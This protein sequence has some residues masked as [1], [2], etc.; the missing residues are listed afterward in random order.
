[1]DPG[2]S[3]R[4]QLW[5]TPATGAGIVAGAAGTAAGAPVRPRP[6]S[7][8]AGSAI[9][10]GGIVSSVAGTGAGLAAS[11]MLLAAGISA[12]A[13]VPPCAVPGSAMPISG[14]VA[15]TG[16][17]GWLYGSL[18]AWSASGVDMGWLNGASGPVGR[19]VGWAV[20]GAGAPTLGPVSA[21][22]HSSQK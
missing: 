3:G 13:P 20:A 19:L 12:S 10:A 4:P 6:M 18:P 9:D 21:A 16:R 14:G 5:Q 11:A 15:A 22:P 17:G 8:A 1:M 2:F 7:D